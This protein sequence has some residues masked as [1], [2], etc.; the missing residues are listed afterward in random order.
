MLEAGTELPTDIESLQALVSSLR[1][2]LKNRDDK[3]ENLI[4]IIRDLKRSRFGKSSEKV[5]PEQLGMFNEAE[6]ADSGEDDLDDDSETE[7]ITYERKKP[8][9]RPLPKELP[10]EDRVV[11]LPESERRCSH[12]PEHVMQEI[13]EEISEKLDIVPMQM[14]VIRTI[15]KKYACCE[16][17]CGLGG[18]KTA[19][20]AAQAIPKSNASEGLLAAIA[21]MKYVDHLP[22]YRLETIFKRHE[23]DLTRGTMASWMVRCG[24]LVQPLINLLHDELIEANYLQMDETRTQVLNEEGK[25]AESQSYMWVRHRPGK[26]PIILFTYDPT[27]S[28]GVPVKL[29]EGF[30]GHLQVDGYDGYAEVVRKSQGKITRGG[31]LAHA[32]RKFKKAADSSK[33]PGLANKGLKLIQKLYKIEDDI[34]YRTPEERHR[35]RQLKAKPII[36]EMRLWLDKVLNSAPPES[37]VGKALNYT[38][39]EWPYLVAYLNDGRYEIDNNEIE[40]A[41]R[42]FALG[43]KNW[44]FSSTVEGADASANLYSL[45]ETAKANYIEPYRYLRY[46]FERLPL[47]QT[48]D[49]FAALLPAAVKAVFVAQDQ[50]KK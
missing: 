30:S 11:D 45:I 46:I 9:R 33:K 37:L 15:R 27:R 1:E 2:E 21:T 18:V 20:V 14:K 8:K 44:L 39:N 32:R 49:D 3:V 13:G 47:A 16:K 41:I 26:N 19:P 40:N 17:D 29:L 31:C 12:N 25:R 6:E 43:R 22:L 42:P 5:S 4:E 24:E 7:S 23:I 35:A 48:A 28:G 50:T 34:R 38:N 36:D 10:R